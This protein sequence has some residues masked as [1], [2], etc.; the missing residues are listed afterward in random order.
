MFVFKLGIVKLKYFWNIRREVKCNKRFLKGI[1][2]KY[3]SVFVR[4]IFFIE[5]LGNFVLFILKI[6]INLNLSVNS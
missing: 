3:L 2:F 1:I 6:F 4:L 5:I